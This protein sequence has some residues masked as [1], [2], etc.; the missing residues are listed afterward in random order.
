M[1]H[2]YK[3]AMDWEQRW[4]DATTPWDAGVSPPTLTKLVADSAALGRV[5]VPGCGA[6]YDVLTLAQRAEVVVGL[7][8][9]PTAQRRFDSLAAGV[10]TTGSA[11][12]V[13][14]D[15]FDF[16]PEARFDVIWDYTFLCA[17]DPARRQAWAARVDALL[18]PDGELWTLIF[19]VHPVPLNPGRPPHPM[20]PELLRALLEPTFAA[21]ELEPVT[22][23]HPGRE[24]KEWFGRW[25]RPS[26][27]E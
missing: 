19:P 3:S 13:V 2:G 15:F 7:E 16:E 8:V 27:I 20:S 18:A 5:L 22:G 25:R 11:T 26:R 17:L 1:T 4:Q 10:E 14:A 6:G 12:V 23:S 21:I 24:G 9:A